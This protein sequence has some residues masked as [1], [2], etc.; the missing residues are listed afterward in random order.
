M[1]DVISAGRTAAGSPAGYRGSRGR[2]PAQQEGVGDGDGRGLRGRE[3]ARQDAG[4]EH[5]CDRY[6]AGRNRVDDH[7]FDGGISR[8]V[9]AA[10]AV[11]ATLNSRLY[12]LR[13]ISGIMKPP[14][15]E[16]ALL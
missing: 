13:F 11:T 8:P 15:K 12:P 14:I 1:L 9:V 2:S 4:H 7:Q 16:T 3:D 5:R 6:R 10:V